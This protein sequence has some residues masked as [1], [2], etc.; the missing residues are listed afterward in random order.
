MVKRNFDLPSSL[1]CLSQQKL[2][3]N[4]EVPQQSFG[5]LYQNHFKRNKEADLIDTVVSC[6]LLCHNKI[7]NFPCKHLSENHKFRKEN[8]FI[9]LISQV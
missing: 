2:N 1:L 6:L 5:F 8:L 7:T 3:S 9:I 4:L